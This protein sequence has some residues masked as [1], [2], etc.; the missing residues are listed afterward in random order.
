MRAADVCDDRIDRFIL[1]RNSCPTS[2][3][4]AESFFAN[5]RIDDCVRY[6]RG[7][8]KARGYGAALPRVSRLRIQIPI[9]IARWRAVAVIQKNA[10]P[11]T[12]WK[13]RIRQQIKSFVVGSVC[14]RIA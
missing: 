9:A 1:K 4:D 3:H 8:D 12:V 6:G 11:A 14:E 10:L 5:D 13:P 7:I 2:N